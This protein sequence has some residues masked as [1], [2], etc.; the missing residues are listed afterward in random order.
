MDFLFVNI[1]EIDALMELPWS[2][3][4]AYLMAI[5]PYMDRKTCLVGIKRRISYQSIREVLYVAPIPGVKT[6]NI[7]LQQVR[8][9][10]KS[11]NRVGLISMH[12][13]DK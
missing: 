11:L 12:S 7:S 1:A 10:V 2:H 8:R 3:R 5:R 6:D 4:I 13:T 9:I